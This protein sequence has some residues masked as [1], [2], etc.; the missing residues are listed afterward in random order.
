MTDRIKRGIH[1]EWFSDKGEV[2]YLIA[3]WGW[4]PEELNEQEAA[5]WMIDRGPRYHYIT[6][7]DVR[8]LV[9]DAT[10]LPG[11]HEDSP[12]V[13]SGRAEDTRRDNLFEVKTEKVAN[14]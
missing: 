11:V 3:D 4:P 1:L 8:Q 10:H 6:R 2:K 7:E 13:P 12:K 5:K 9:A 14:D